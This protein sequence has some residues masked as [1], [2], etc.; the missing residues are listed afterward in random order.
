MVKYIKNIKDKIE[1][2]IESPEFKSLV[3]LLSASLRMPRRK[4]LKADKEGEILVEFIRALTKE[5]TKSFRTEFAGLIGLK[6]SG[7]NSVLYQRNITGKHLANFLLQL[8]NTTAEDF[9]SEF[10]HYLIEK[11]QRSN[12]PEWLKLF[13]KIKNLTEE[14]KTYLA[15]VGLKL[16]QMIENRK[17]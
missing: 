7:L 16:D 9:I 4:A 13:M 2:D 11:K 12:P 17:K 6:E 8:T 10:F 15:M 14:E 1:I 3:S 5:S